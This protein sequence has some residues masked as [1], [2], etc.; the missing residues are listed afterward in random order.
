MTATPLFATPFYAKSKR[1]SLHKSHPTPDVVFLF[2]NINMNTAVHRAT[3]GKNRSNLGAFFSTARAAR[4]AIFGTHVVLE[5]HYNISFAMQY[6]LFY[7]GNYGG[8][9]NLFFPIFFKNGAFVGGCLYT[10]F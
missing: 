2:V 1:S 5:G 3:K 10:A 7:F 8:L 4:A 6:F 9:K